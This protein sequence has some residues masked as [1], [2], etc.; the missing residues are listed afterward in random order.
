[1]MKIVRF[2]YANS[3]FGENN[4]F[5]G[6]CK[7]NLLPISFCIYLIETENKKILVDVGCNSCW[8]F[9]FENFIP[10]VECLK[11]YGLQPEEVTDVVLTHSHYDHIADIKH[12]K[13]SVIHIQRDEYEEGEKYIPE[14]FKVELFDDEIEIDKDILV[15]KIAGHSIGSSIVLVKNYIICGD[16]CYVLKCLTDKIPTGATRDLK[17]SKDFVNKYGDKNY[18]PLLLHDPSLEDEVIPIF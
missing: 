18:I 14:D 5:Y 12:Y 6:G 13:N 4:I 11:N 9:V 16:E 15:K 3:V 8:G 2:K 1:M 7:D 10:P 17:L